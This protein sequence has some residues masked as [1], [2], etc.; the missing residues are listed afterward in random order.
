MERARKDTKRQKDDYEYKVR[1]LNEKI[2]NLQT[3]L[4]NT[5]TDLAYMKKVKESL[6]GE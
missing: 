4:E 1:A 5:K 6:E 3:N 2:N